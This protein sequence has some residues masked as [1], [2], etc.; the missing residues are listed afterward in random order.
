LSGVSPEITSL[1][2]QMSLGVI[3]SKQKTLLGREAGVAI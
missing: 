1:S 3:N 2:T